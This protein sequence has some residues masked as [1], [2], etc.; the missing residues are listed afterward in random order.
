[1]FV[2]F[3]AAAF[4]T[5]DRAHLAVRDTT[6]REE[7][8]K[9]LLTRAT[10]AAA[11]ESVGLNQL[12]SRVATLTTDTLASHRVARGKMLEDLRRAWVADST[13]V[14]AKASYD[15]LARA[16]ADSLYTTEE[17]ISDLTDD[18]RKD[19][20]SVYSDGAFAIAGVLIAFSGFWGWHRNQVRLDVILDRKAFGAGPPRGRRGR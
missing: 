4:N 8:V 19:I 13:V 18:V 1:M 20:S 12:D 6:K 9:R 10:A 2:I 14:A 7:H 11:A 16:I 5:L 3:S 17:S 15:T